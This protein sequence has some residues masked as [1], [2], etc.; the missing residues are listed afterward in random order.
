MGVRNIINAIKGTN[1]RMLQTST[2]E[3]YGDCLISPQ[4]EEYW[5]NVNCNGPRACYDEGKR[6]AEA[7]I[8]DSIRKCN[9]DIRV[10]RIFNTYGP[11][12]NKNDGRVVS[13]FFYQAI[14]NENI[15]IYGDGAQTRSFCYVD[16][17]IEAIY[18]LMNLQ[19]RVEHPINVGNIV[20]LRIK[21]IA[22]TIKKIT[23]SSSN[24]IY[25]N[26]MVDDPKKRKPD[27]TK[28]KEILE[29]EPRVTLYEGLK[30][31]YI[32]YLN[33]IKEK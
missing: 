24:I 10:V 29:W 1:T 5:G 6:A 33:S 16:D 15:T 14:K 28:A 31:S 18:R 20:E 4:T 27:I 22:Q 19:T 12:M 30:N 21:E 7:L 11:N 13:N 9:I 25:L 8:Y 17:T 3:V 26:K 32:F 23:K 2:S